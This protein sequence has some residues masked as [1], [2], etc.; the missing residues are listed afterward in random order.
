[1]KKRKI[2]RKLT[3]PYAR[4]STRV[5][6]DQMVYIKELTAKN[7]TSTEGDTWRMIVDYYWKNHK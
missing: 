4:V 6:K 5:R 7:E 2:P 3:E 1:M